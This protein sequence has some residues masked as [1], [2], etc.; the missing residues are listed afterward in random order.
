MNV[1]RIPLHSVVV[2]RDGK[3]VT[4]PLDKPFNFTEQ[5]IKDAGE[6][7]FREP[8]VEVIEEDPVDTSTKAPAAKTA[9]KA[10]GKADESL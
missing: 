4:P 2:V 9:G 5:E 1:T 6:H 8:K 7:A 10:K 3:F